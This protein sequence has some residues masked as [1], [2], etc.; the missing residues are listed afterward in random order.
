MRT[1]SLDMIPGG[2]QTAIA[3]NQYESGDTWV[4]AL[5]YDGGRYS[6]PEDAEVSITGT[7]PDGAAYKIAGTVVDNAV[8][9]VVTDQITACAGRSIAE[10]LVESETDGTVL[11]SANFPLLV[12]PAAVQGDL[13]P[14]VIPTS[15]VDADGNIYYEGKSI[16]GFYP[17]ESASGDVAVIHDGADDLPVRDLSVAIEPIQAGTGTPSPDNV[18]AIT[19][20]YAVEVARTDGNGDNADTHT[21]TLPTTV[22]GGTLDVTKGILTVDRAMVDLG[23]LAWVYSNPRFYATAPADSAGISD[24]GDAQALCDSFDRHETGALA[25]MPDASFFVNSN[26]MSASVK[27]IVVRDGRYTDASAFKTA[28]DGVMLCYTLATPVT[29]TLTPT[30]VKTLLGENRIY[31]DAGQVTVQYRADFNEAGLMYIPKAPTADGTYRL[32]ADVTG[33][34]PTYR[35]EAAE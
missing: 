29:Y 2:A 15:I 26:K 6:I 34:T 16:M 1:F 17:V 9:I 21:I 33:G 14:S 32:T 19:G 24:T 35:W 18:R 22:Y 10:I 13:S 30:E 25:N 7:K 12:E 20:W 3:C 31:A 28:M 11:Y 27:R 5:Y 4:F 23:T 8:Q